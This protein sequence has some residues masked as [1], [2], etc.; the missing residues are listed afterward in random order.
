[1]PGCR[2][3][4]LGSGRRRPNALGWSREHR[5]S[6]DI[7]GTLPGR[8]L[9]MWNVETPPWSGQRL[10]GSTV[11]KTEFLWREQ[12]GPRSQRRWPKGSRK[13]CRVSRLLRRSARIIGRI[14]G[15]CSGLEDGADVGQV[16]LWRSDDDNAW[17]RNGRRITSRSVSV[18]K[19]VEKIVGG[20]KTHSS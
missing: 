5:R 8:V 11:R 1:M 12:D 4:P 16:S 19:C 14:P 2:G 7:G 6:R 15:Y 13:P 3:W 17:G 9:R 18:L 20:Q 10:G